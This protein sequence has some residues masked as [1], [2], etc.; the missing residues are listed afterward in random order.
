MSFHRCEN[1]GTGNAAGV[2]LCANCRF[3]LG[4]DAGDYC[5]CWS[6]DQWYLINEMTEIG[7]GWYCPSCLANRADQLADDGTCPDCGGSGG[8]EGRWRC[9][10]CRG[11]GHV[12]TES[13]REDKWI[14][15]EMKADERRD[16]KM[17]KEGK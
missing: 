2:T 3:P 1:C 4:R 17:T 11:K 13:E 10:T 14:A 6:C 12:E 8:G 7:D 16:E 15:A 9:P 5:V